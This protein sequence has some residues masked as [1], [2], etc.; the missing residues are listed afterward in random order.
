MS[1]CCVCLHLCDWLSVCE[2]VCADGGPL[3][4]AR[5]Y[6]C[7]VRVSALCGAGTAPCVRPELEAR[8]DVGRVLSALAG[9]TSLIVD[10]SEELARQAAE[11]AR[12]QLQREA[13]RVIV[14]VIVCVSV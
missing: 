5:A 13:V 4:L 6:E 2:C 10:N 11:E 1:P 12:A 14:C 9:M 3:K 8:T 7:G